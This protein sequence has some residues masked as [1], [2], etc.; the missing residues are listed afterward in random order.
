M[1]DNDKNKIGIP[2][3]VKSRV[4]SVWHNFKYG[5]NYFQ[6]KTSFSEKSPVWLLGVPYSRNKDKNSEFEAFKGDF[7]SR[8]W[9]SYRKDLPVF[10][11]TDLTSDAGWG[12]MLRSTQM[13]ISQ[14]L[15]LHTEGRQPPSSLQDRNINRR[16]IIK[17]FSESE[18]SSDAP[19]SIQN[20]VDLSSGVGR[21][22][23]NW[24]GPA[25]AAYLVQM[26]WLKNLQNP[27]EGVLD[28]LAIYVAQD[29]TVYK[30]DV[31]TI[32]TG[33]SESTEEVEG[34]SVV[35]S[36]SE[37]HDRFLPGDPAQTSEQFLTSESADLQYSFSEEVTVGEE[38]SWTLPT[39]AVKNEWKSV[40]ILVPIRVGGEKL[41]P[42]YSSCLTSLLTL[43]CCIGWVGGRPS[44]SLY[45][46]GFQ[47]QF[48]INLDPHRVQ[49]LID[50]KQ[51]E[52]DLSTFMCKN[53]RKISINKM[54]PSCCLGFYIRTRDEFE[55][56]CLEIEQYVTPQ[57]ESNPASSSSTR[58]TSQYPLFT[59]Q[60]K[61]SIDVQ[62]QQ[63]QPS[64]PVQSSQRLQS[65]DDWVKMENNQIRGSNVQTVQTS[66]KQDLDSEEF[67]FL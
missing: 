40:V 24:F 57:P 29:C 35:E 21:G 13:M 63:S 61:Q 20:L 42:V 3:T 18:D 34:F 27:V 22:A 11:G 23:G 28:D 7:E 45:F 15:L 9:F 44:H 31:L 50:T 1:D 2:Q 51:P 33:Q 30:H 59:V 26:A 64:K 39:H 8:I 37:T 19:F 55:M 5:K 58:T 17:L 65:V 12:C 48:L 32:C 14:A 4:E 41:N 43:P 52:F 60:H 10:G 6:T 25:T 38:T 66:N 16:R 56:W 49:P 36:P 47:D 54:D 67:V 62:T 46:I 53:A